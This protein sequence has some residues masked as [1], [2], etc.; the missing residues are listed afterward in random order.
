M[1]G[2]VTHVL[3][4]FFGTLVAYSD[5][6]TEQGYRRSYSLLIEAGAALDYPGYLALW[7]EV[8]EAFEQRAV[9]SHR[10]YTM[11]AVAGAFLVRALGPVLP[12]QLTGDFVSAYLD[13]WNAG[14]RYL[15]GLSGMLGRLAERFTLAV[16]TNTHDAAL[17]PGHLHRM[18]VS[19][20]F[21]KVV[22]SVELGVRKPAAQIFQHALRELDAS[23][24][25]AVYVGDSFEADYCGARSAGL[26]G[27]LI[28]PEARHPVPA[29]ERLGSIFELE[30][31][32]AGALVRLPSS[33]ASGSRESCRR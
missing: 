9:A 8:A 22:T 26:R 32:L 33:L 17:V 3:F 10:E 11:E 13:E 16:I 24:D 20:H 18:G 5:S 19:G 21:A 15:A 23:A 30:S 1:P 12:A 4:D 6:R 29:A 2:S 31:S 27:M 25:C 14:V 7:E 28:D